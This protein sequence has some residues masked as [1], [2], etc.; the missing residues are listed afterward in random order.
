MRSLKCA[1][2]AGNLKRLVAVKCDALG[3]LLDRLLSTYKNASSRVEMKQRVKKCRG[4]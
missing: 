4:K 3:L 1:K 2:T